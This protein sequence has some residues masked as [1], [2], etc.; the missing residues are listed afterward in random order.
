MRL[1]RIARSSG[2]ALKSALFGGLLLFAAACATVQQPQVEAFHQGV[3]TAKLQLDTAFAS[4]N[5]MVTADEIDR[6]I[7]LPN[8]KEEDVVVVLDADSIARWDT[9]FA[10]IDQYAA[11][12]SL[13]ISPDNANEFGTATEGLAAS[14]AQ[15]SP[16]ALPSTGVSTA[17]AEFGRLLIEVKSQHDAVAAARTADPGIQQVFSEMAAVI[18]ESNKTEGSLRATVRSHWQLRMDAKRADFLA[19][20]GD[21]RRSI[22]TDYIDYRDRRDAQDL[23]L[24][25]LRQSILDLATAHGALARGSNVDLNSA[26]ALI[27]QELDATRALAEKFQSLKPKPQG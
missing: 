6:A 8:L 12:L 10:K 1:A 22:V 27:Q 25:M 19:V 21:A 3:D 5:Q 11:N 9:A 24:G 7:T 18:G 26:I 17:F 23:Q 4:I 13:L 15:L 2:S 20:Q 14:L 16:N